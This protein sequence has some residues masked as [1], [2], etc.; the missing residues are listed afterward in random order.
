[1]KFRPLPGYSFDVNGRTR[2]E[3]GEMHMKRFCLV[4]SICLTLVPFAQ[5]QDEEK[6]KALFQ[7]AIQAM[8]GDA[9]LKAADMVSNGQRFYFNNQGDSSGLI[10]FSNYTKFP[11]KR[12]FEQGNRKNELDITVFNL[13]I[14]K[15]WILEGQK[16]TREARPEEMKE[17]KEAVKHSIN[18]IFR[19]RYKDPANKLF[20][21]GPGEGQ[22]ITLE[23]VK[24]L[25]QEND[26]VT[27]Y[28]D[29]ISKLPAKIEYASLSNKGIRQ[30]IVEEFSQWH[31]FQ[32]VNTPLR[33]DSFVNG[34]RLLQHFVNKISYNNNLPDSFFST[35]TPPK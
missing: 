15:G 8:G 14:N 31:E 19:F 6:I 20:Y 25:D 34:R 4:L 21:L 16:G 12:R 9:Y 7:D 3:C 24:L 30:H 23:M 5:G 11:D 28:F 29:R 10:K 22:D 32:G 26:E 33:I 18:N 1:L 35:L 2:I 27:V 13:E 17:F